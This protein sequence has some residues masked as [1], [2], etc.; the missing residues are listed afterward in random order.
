MR[1]HMRAVCDPQNAEGE[2]RRGHDQDGVHPEER[3]RSA[4]PVLTRPGSV[5]A[6]DGHREPRPH[7]D[8]EQASG[9]QEQSLNF[10]D[11]P[12]IMEEAA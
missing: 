5:I 4:V 7:D 12:T 6:T 11:H 8:V 9:H 3:R 2:D 10:G 1:R